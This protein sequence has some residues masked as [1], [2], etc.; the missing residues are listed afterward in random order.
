MLA[1]DTT[2][3][4]LLEHSVPKTKP[5]HNKGRNPQQHTG[6]K[7]S[8][9]IR[10]IYG[11]QPNLPVKTVHAM[12]AKENIKCSVGLISSVR[13]RM[14]KPEGKRNSGV[15]SMKHLLQI[16]KLVT[17]MGVENFKALTNILYGTKGD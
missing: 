9:R 10:E 14:S 5:H 12:L 3:N 7:A 1:V 16:K 4:S 15:V 13:Y 17:E 8:A 6:G 2:P 11:E